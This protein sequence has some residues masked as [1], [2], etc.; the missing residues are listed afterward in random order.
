MIADLDFY[1]VWQQTGFSIAVLWR[2]NLDEN[3][4]A[5]RMRGG[6]RGEA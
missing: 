4:A 1:G 3:G 5:I 6:G 2:D